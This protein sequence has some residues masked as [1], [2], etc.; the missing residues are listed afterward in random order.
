V[1]ALARITLVCVLSEVLALGDVQGGGGD[2]LVERVWCA[3]EVLAGVA[4]AMAVLVSAI[5]AN[6]S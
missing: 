3:R 1:N 5:H 6:S 4:M 2:D